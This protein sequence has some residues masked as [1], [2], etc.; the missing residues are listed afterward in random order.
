MKLL[1][2]F[3]CPVAVIWFVHL[4]RQVELKHMT[5]MFPQHFISGGSD[6]PWRAHSPD[7]S[8]C[9][10][11]LWSYLKSNILISK[12]RTIEELK[13]RIKDEIAAIQEQ[14]IHWVKENLQGRFEQYLRISGRHLST[15][16]FTTQNGMYLSL[17]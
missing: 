16:L 2:I 15:V 14:M 3:G 7:L 5:K 11:F 4:T 12:L 10:Y 9:D 13:Q 17:Q 6:V 8:A 1:W